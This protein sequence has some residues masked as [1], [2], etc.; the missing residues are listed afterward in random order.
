MPD[1]LDTQTKRT[2]G[3]VVYCSGLENPSRQLPERAVLPDLCAYDVA[4]DALFTSRSASSDGTEVGTAELTAQL[5]DWL[6]AIVRAEDQK[7]AD[8]HKLR[9][10]HTIRASMAHEICNGILSGPHLPTASQETG[11]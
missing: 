11:Q 10:W 6:N 2:G 5:V 1:S 8:N 9:G 7:A 3:R 4:R